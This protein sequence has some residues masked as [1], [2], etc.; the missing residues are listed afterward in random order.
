MINQKMLGKWT[1]LHRHGNCS[2]ICCRLKETHIKKL[3]KSIQR[4]SLWLTFT[5]QKNMQT[6]IQPEPPAV[7]WDYCSSVPVAVLLTVLSWCKTLI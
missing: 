6:E 4:V 2:H 7:L 1:E 3:H 5:V